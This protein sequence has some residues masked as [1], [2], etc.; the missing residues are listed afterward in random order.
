MSLKKDYKEIIARLN[1]LRRVEPTGDLNKK[2][3]RVAVILTGSRSGSSL[4]KTVVS[5]SNDVAYLSGEE[6]PFFI[7]S[8]NGFPWS[9]DSDGFN[10]LKNKQQLLDN[11]FDDLGI[12]DKVFNLSKTLHD[13]RN[14]ILLQ[15]PDVSDDVIDYMLPKYVSKFYTEGTDYTEATQKLLFTLF[16]EHAGLYDVCDGKYDFMNQ[17]FK[18]EEPPFVIPP[19]RRRFTE[20]DIEDKVLVFKTPQ[21]CY[22]VGIFE[23]LFP[24]ADIK[25]IH[26]T[27]GFAQTINGL[28]DGWLSDTGFFAHDVSIINEELNIKGYSDVKPFGNKWWKF[29][30]PPNWKDYKDAP[31][32]EVCLNQWYSAHTHILN[33]GKQFLHIKFEDFLTDPTATVAKITDY[34]GINPI[35][36]DNIPVVMATEKPEQFRWLKRSALINELSQRSEVKELMEA[37][38]YKMEPE[39]WV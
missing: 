36:V 39:L 27:R 11:L 24:N 34:L 38:T 7:L 33:S 37:L 29:D 22:R 8:G 2:V 15:F 12:N 21:D 9:S 18:I 13:W 10:T 25:Y 1:S 6:E 31:L 32:H 20:A 3:K 5:R 23:Q 14:R 16:K 19:Q 35:N 30:L 17:K 4:M 26:L 28:M